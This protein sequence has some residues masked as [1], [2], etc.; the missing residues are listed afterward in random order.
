MHILVVYT[1]A[2]CVTIVTCLQLAAGATHET[3]HLWPTSFTKH[4][5]PSP[6]DESIHIQPTAAVWSSS[7]IVPHEC[8]W[9]AEVHAVDVDLLTSHA[10]TQTAFAL[11]TMSAQQISI[12]WTQEVVATS[13]TRAA[14]K[15][16]QALIQCLLPWLEVPNFN[17]FGTYVFPPARYVLTTSFRV[18]FPSQQ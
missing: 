6:S 12:A 11:G 17:A 3:L 5:V 8:D 18:I 4:D 16:G 14:G 7:F 9:P 10:G 15:T 13:D 1:I 2:I